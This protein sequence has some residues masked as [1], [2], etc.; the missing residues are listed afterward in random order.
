M[1][2]KWS[3]WF[4]LLNESWYYLGSIEFTA[5]WPKG[6]DEMIFCSFQISWIIRATDPSTQTNRPLIPLVV[7]FKSMHRKKLLEKYRM[8]K[9]LFILKKLN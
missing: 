3:D 9:L 5:K 8:K 6:R 1:E 4:E 2:N 7:N